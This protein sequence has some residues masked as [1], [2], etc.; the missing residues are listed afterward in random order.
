MAI[1][2]RLFALAEREF[3][4][5]RAAPVRVKFK[6]LKLNIGRYDETWDRRR[7]SAAR[8]MGVVLR[9]SDEALFQRVCSDAEQAK[10][11]R[12]AAGWLQ[13]EAEHVRRHA[14]L[15]DTAVARL[16]AV[17]DRCQEVSHG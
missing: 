9:E 3:K 13:R 12:D 11:Y 5:N 2:N 14:T 10:M 17:L 4:A 7:G 15:L 1:G 16:T 8:M 6:G